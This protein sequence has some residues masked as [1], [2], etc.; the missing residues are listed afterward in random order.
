MA[1]GGDPEA[2]HGIVL[3]ANYI[4]KRMGV[5]TGMALWQARQVC[6]QIVFI[7]PHYDQYIRFSR[8]AR[9]IYSS[10]TDQQEPFGLDECWLDVTESTSIKGEGLKIA[11]EISSRI[12]KE[13]G[14]TVSIGVSWNKIFAKL[15]SD[16]KKPEAITVFTQENFRKLIWPLPAIRRYCIPISERSDMCCIPMRTAGM[17]IR[18]VRKDMRHR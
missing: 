13:L 6:P 15:G 11:E 2:R 1:V 18:S 7:S 12:K 4:A 14:I 5:K 17:M 16:Y 9:E 8:Y 10:F 3:T